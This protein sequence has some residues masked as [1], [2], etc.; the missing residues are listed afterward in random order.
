[1]ENHFKGNEVGALGGR[2]RKV[3]V[4]KERIPPFV[5]SATSLQM[6]RTAKRGVIEVDG[7]NSPEWSFRG[8]DRTLLC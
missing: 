2:K 1:M 6:G 3:S 4:V 8:F 5:R 7:E